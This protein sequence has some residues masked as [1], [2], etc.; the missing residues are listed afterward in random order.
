MIA[1]DTFSKA[2]EAILSADSLLIIAGAGMD[3][4]SGLGDYR[5]EQDC[6]ENYSDFIRN[7]LLF[8]EMTDPKLFIN[9]PKRAWGFY[10][11]QYNLYKQ[12]TPHSGYE[13][14]N[15]WCKSKSSACFVYTSNINGFF[16]KSGFSEKSM[17]ESHGTINYFQCATPCNTD[18]WYEPN[19]EFEIDDEL[20]LANSILPK[21]KKCGGVS[22]PNALAFKDPYWLQYRTEQQETNYKKWQTINENK[23][24]AIIELGVS[25]SGFSIHHASC[26]SSD[27]TIQINSKSIRDHKNTLSIKS[28]PQYALTTIN[29]Y[30]NEN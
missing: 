21:C 15:K 22:R 8:K 14:L 1:T 7:T 16:R 18:I 13:I 5:G 20:L 26:K 27:T 17:Y 29:K 2:A 10:G 25:N 23:N 19:L 24:I 6:F 28:T 9:D 4:D 11:F 12:T 30:L 3:D